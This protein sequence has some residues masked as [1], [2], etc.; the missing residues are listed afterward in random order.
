MNDEMVHGDVNP[1]KFCE[2]VNEQVL[3]SR[4]VRVATLE[5]VPFMVEVAKSAY[6]N[7]PIERGVP[8]IEWCIKSSERLVLVG[9]HSFGVAHI[10]WH[11][12]FE[13]S[14]GLVALASR[15]EARAAF[16]TLHMLRFMI[17][18]AK[19]RGATGVFTLDADTGTDFG[20]F[21]ARL[22]AKRVHLLQY[23][24]PLNPVAKEIS[25]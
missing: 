14:S 15:P 21:A 25:S 2:E 1:R 4:T 20:P 12:G 24:I 3:S 6:P 16:E 5:D 17:E 11:Y 8:W 10:T 13:L 9:S 19:I 22:G 23:H 7:R 18:W